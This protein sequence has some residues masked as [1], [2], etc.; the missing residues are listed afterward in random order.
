MDEVLF[1]IKLL[2]DDIRR[3]REE[4]QRLPDG[5]YAAVPVFE[6]PQAAVKYESLRRDVEEAEREELASLLQELHE[7]CCIPTGVWIRD[8]R[9]YFKLNKT[10]TTE[11]NTKLAITFKEGE[12]GYGR[13]A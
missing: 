3:M 10:T 1:D 7:E 8:E 13:A 5:Y 12:L 4:M 2:L 11:G 6:D 9:G